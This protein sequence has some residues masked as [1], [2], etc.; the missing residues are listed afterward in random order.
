[1]EIDRFQNLMP[2]GEDQCR[3]ISTLGESAGNRP[4]SNGFGPGSDDQPYV[5]KTQYSP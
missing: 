2:A 1:M 4:Q 5:R 3:E